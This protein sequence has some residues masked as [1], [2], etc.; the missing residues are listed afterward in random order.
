MNR[1]QIFDKVATHLFTQGHQAIKLSRCCYRTNIEGEACAIGCL[2]P[3][4]VYVPS[5]ESLNAVDLANSDTKIN[6]LP[7]DIFNRGNARFLRELQRVHDRRVSWKSTVSMQK[8][9]DLVAREENLDPSLLKTLSF[10]DK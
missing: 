4:E 1:Q 5:L 6:G 8:A 2:I 9:L 10:K 3:D 7:S